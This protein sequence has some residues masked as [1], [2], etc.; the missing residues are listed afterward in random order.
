MT[1]EVSGV[2]VSRSCATLWRMKEL[3]EVGLHPTLLVGSFALLA[4]LPSPGLALIASLLLAYLLVTWC[5]RRFPAHPEWRQPAREQATV[6]T[7]SAVGFVL[8]GVFAELYAGW[9][10]APLARVRD[11]AGVDAWPSGW[12]APVQIL[13]FFFVTELIFYW[14]HRGL[15]RSA[16]LWR[17]SGHGLH[18]SFRNMHAP[19]FIASHLGDLALLAVP[20]A[21]AAGALGASAEVIAG[22]AILQT[23]NGL[24]AHANVRART[25]LLGLVITTSDQHRLHHSADFAQSNTNYSCNAILW[26]R[27]FGTFAEGSVRQTGI[28]PRELSLVEKLLLPFR[29]PSDV[30]TSPAAGLART[31]AAAE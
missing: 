24:A 16:A 26:D 25:P 11:I 15:H 4:W 30:E 27:L 14:I 12:P 23:V 8:L 28:G 29:E 20:S 9:I 5:E 21:L 17:V 22:T 7:L 19:A 3:V 2:D 18:H 1:S 31:G 6:L 10:I 13:S